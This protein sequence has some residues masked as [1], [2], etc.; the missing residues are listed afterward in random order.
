MKWCVSVFRGVVS[1]GFIVCSGKFW[2]PGDTEQVQ[3]QR[4]L[5]GSGQEPGQGWAAIA[6][7]S[8]RPPGPGLSSLDPSVLNFEREAWRTTRDEPTES[9]QNS[10]CGAGVVHSGSHRDGFAVFTLS[11]VQVQPRQRPPVCPDVS[12]V[13]NSRTS[14]LSLT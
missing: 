7:G 5:M 1:D 6:V 3:S 4:R 14:V 8:G 2:V 11:S 12:H 10:K 9:I 13:R